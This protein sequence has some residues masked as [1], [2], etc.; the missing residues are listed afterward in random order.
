MVF[1]GKKM[2]TGD[3]NIDLCDSFYIKLKFRTKFI[4]GE[5]IQIL[6]FL[7]LN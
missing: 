3:I 7:S 2:C 1:K 5:N 6:V 4:P